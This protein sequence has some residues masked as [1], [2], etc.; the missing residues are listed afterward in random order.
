MDALG[1]TDGR[2]ERAPPPL[3][4]RVDAVE[5]AAA[6]LRM[7]LLRALGG[8]ASAGA[9]RRP[10]RTSWR[11]P[12]PYS[13]AVLVADARDGALRRVHAAA[14]DAHVQWQDGHDVADA[15]RRLALALS[16]AAEFD[17]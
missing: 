16:V 3:A 17:A 4:T 6:A 15:M 10:G 8:V 9:R 14:R 11:Q 1:A 7:R 13:K 2:P 12:Q 5:A